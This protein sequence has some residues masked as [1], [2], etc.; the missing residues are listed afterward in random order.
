MTGY[1]LALTD[2]AFLNSN[3]AVAL[4]PVRYGKQVFGM[5]NGE[6]K[7]VRMRFE[8]SLAGVVIDRFGK[9]VMLIPDGDDHFTCAEEIMVSPV[10]YAWIASFGTRAR[11]LSPDSVVEGF[12]EN[13]KNTLELYRE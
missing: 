4:A 12:V 1:Q 3:G 10:F 8:N 13:R 9:D 6:L 7:N 2:E 5:F 11:L